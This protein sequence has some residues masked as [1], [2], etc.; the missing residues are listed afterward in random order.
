MRVALWT[1]DSVDGGYLSRFGGMVIVA[2]ASFLASSFFLSRAYVFPVFF[3]FVVLNAV[4]IVAGSVLSDQTRPLALVGRRLVIYGTVGTV[5]SVAYI[6][7]AILLL[8]IAHGGGRLGHG[9]GSG[10]MGL[11]QA[12]LAHAG[13][14]NR[15]GKSL[16]RLDPVEGKIIE[17]RRSVD[18][19][20]LI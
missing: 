10:N 4:V 19:R 3:L 8:N 2:T 15:S 14:E 9:N 17:F 7:V 20:S 13:P 11:R 6:Y 5:V 18:Q 16:A 1:S 12:K